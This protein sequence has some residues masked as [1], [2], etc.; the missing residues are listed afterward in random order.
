[1]GG[2]VNR[3]FWGRVEHH[4]TLDSKLPFSSKPYCDSKLRDL[5]TV[6]RDW[7]EANG[8]H[9]FLPFPEWI[10]SMGKH[11]RGKVEQEDNCRPTCPE[12]KQRL[13]GNIP[14]SRIHTRPKG[15]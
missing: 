15:S 4:S 11:K 7:R 10:E 13:Q 1:M 5:T 3:R 9:S 6:T 12:Q 2:T 14:N 8:M